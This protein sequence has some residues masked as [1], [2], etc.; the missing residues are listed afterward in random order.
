MINLPS[1]LRLFHLSFRSALISF[2]SSDRS[3]FRIPVPGLELHTSDNHDSGRV[4][5]PTVVVANTVSTMQEPAV[6][7]PTLQKVLP[8]CSAETANGLATGRQPG[9]GLNSSEVRGN[10]CLFS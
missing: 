7:L 1:I 2:I 10:H 6:R 5:S 3:S 4:R 9:L 8:K